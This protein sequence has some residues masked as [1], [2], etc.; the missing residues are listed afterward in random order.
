[1]RICSRTSSATAAGGKCKDRS[2]APLDR[3]PRER[4]RR[5]PEI[6]L[7]DQHLEQI[8][9]HH[10]HALGLARPELP[11]LHHQGGCNS[12]RGEPGHEGGHSLAGVAEP[13]DGGSRP[14]RHESN[15]DERQGQYEQPGGHAAGEDDFRAYSRPGPHTSAPS[16]SDVTLRYE[17]WTSCD[18]ATWT[19]GNDGNSLRMWKAGQ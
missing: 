12:R 16:L 15:R 1:M 14:A 13:L 9:L 10:P 5:R 3:R 4:R 2:T 8:D 18:R 7:L 19:S 11:D 17:T 6:R